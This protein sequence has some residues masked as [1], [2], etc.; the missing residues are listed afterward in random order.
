MYLDL[1]KRALMHT[2]YWP[3]DLE[4]STKPDAFVVEE[5][6]AAVREAREQGTV[7]Y[8]RARIEG[9]DW[10]KYGQTM[11]GQARLDNV[12]HCVE[13]V[14]AEGIPGDLIET[15]VWRGGVTILMRAVLHAYGVDDR[16]VF[17]ADSFKGLPPPNVEAY[18]ADADDV[19]HTAKE[20]AVSREDVERNFRMYGLLD[21][22][23]QFLEGW[24]SETLP[25]VKDRTW[26]VIRVDG[27]MYESTMDT[28]VNLYPGLAPGGF[29][30]IDDGA[31]E[32][33]RQAVDDFRGRHGVTEALQAIDWT[34]MY[35]RRER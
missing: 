16:T 24:F 5:F 22:Q 8:G 13:T 35:W 31:Y 26:S 4:W 2:L 33:C 27:D 1:V 32:P 18:P 14:I 30:V 15:G 7:D 9:R 23:V 6:A 11:V 28:L 20:L 3:P 29:L 19:H 12:Q 21:D 10:P 25:T 17:A 34:G